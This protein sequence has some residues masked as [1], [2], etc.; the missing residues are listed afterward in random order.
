MSKA[1]LPRAKDKRSGSQRMKEK[2]SL[3]LPGSHWPPRRGI[4]LVGARVGDEPDSKWLIDGQMELIL[5]TRHQIWWWKEKNDKSLKRQ[6]AFS[7][8]LK[9]TFAYRK[10]TDISGCTIHWVLPNIYTCNHHCNPG[11]EEFSHPRE[12]PHVAHSSQAL[13]L[14]STP[15]S[16]WSVHHVSSFAF[17]RVS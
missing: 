13:L 4:S 2:P 11:L 5:E 15:G 12:F 10:F 14:P 17:S 7:L 6:R 3:W 1:H 8:F 9:I 16:L